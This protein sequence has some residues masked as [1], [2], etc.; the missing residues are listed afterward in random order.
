[1]VRRA[2]APSFSVEADLNGAAARVVLRG[3]LDLTAAAAL[4]EM[5][6]LVLAKAP[7]DIVLQMGRVAFI[8]CACAR[9]I[10][11]AARALPGPGRLVIQSPSPVVRRLFHLSGL[12][13]VVPVGETACPQPVPLPAIPPARKPAGHIRTRGEGAQAASA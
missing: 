5:L 10:A 4:E 11:E 12:D 7:R 1:M 13:A 9:V 3:E 8:D 6:A 2:R